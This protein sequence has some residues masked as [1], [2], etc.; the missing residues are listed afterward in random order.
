[1][2][3]HSQGVIVTSVC[4]LVDIIA[5]VTGVAHSNNFPRRLPKTAAAAALDAADATLTNHLVLSCGGVCVCVCSFGFATP[6]WPR[7]M[8]LIRV[9]AKPRLRCMGVVTSGKVLTRC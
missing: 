3:L 5:C 9:Q 2:C 8:N 1:M 6:L 7:R 4:F